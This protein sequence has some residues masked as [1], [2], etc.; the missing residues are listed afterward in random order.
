MFCC[1]P[2]GTTQEIIKLLATNSPVKIVD[3]SADFRLKDV[4]SYAKW[5]DKPHIAPELQKEAVYGIPE[6]NRNEIKNA[7][8]L[9][10]PG[11]YPTAAQLPLVPL[12]S[13]GFITDQ[14]IIIDAKSGIP[15]LANISCLILSYVYYFYCKEQLVLEELR[16]KRFFIVK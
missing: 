7:R 14:D 8:L 4:D 3:L 1:L 11:C 2:H 12:L 10:N 9:A 13:G 5:Y 6:I 16:K 15:L